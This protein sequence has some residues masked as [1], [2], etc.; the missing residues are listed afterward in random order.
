VRDIYVF[1]MDF[2]TNTYCFPIQR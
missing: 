1:C 2:R